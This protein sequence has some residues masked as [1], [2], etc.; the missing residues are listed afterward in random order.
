M[1]VFTSVE[2]H[3]KQILDNIAADDK[4]TLHSKIH[5]AM[6]CMLINTNKDK[7]GLVAYKE[8]V[9]DGLI[10][11]RLKTTKAIVK[12]VRSQFFGD[13]KLAPG[14]GTRQISSK[15]AIT[16]Q[17]IA[18]RL[19]EAKKF[20]QATAEEFDDLDNR[21]QMLESGVNELKRDVLRSIEVLYE[22][23]K[24]LGQGLPSRKIKH[25]PLLP[26]RENEKGEPLI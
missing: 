14:K 21:L 7:D 12:G 1:D 16:L 24:E 13:L 22:I 6:M 23:K 11:E 26:R 17:A 2:E 8:G 20:H 9:D 18:E 5:S 3:T 15:E 4:Q 10:A 25:E 19:E